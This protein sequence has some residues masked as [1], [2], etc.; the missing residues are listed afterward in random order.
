M[1]FNSL[2]NS[3]PFYILRESGNVPTLVV[4]TIKEKTA[5]M[6]KYQA[7]AIPTAFNGTNVQ[8]F[9]SITVSVDGKDE[10]ITDVPSNIEIAQR[11]KETFTGSREAM[12]QAVDTMIQT[13]KKSLERVD[14]HKSVL[15]EGE[16]MLE[17]L[18]PRYAEEKKQAITIKSLEQRQVETEKKLSSLEAQNSEMLAILRQLNDTPSKN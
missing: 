12:I 10:V 14:Y 17:T 18:N 4:G 13:S 2:T 5:P 9:I 1:D 11:G 16:K 7:Q 3:S 6:P 8:Q 15:V